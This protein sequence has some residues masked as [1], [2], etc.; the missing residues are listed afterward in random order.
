MVIK[1]LPNETYQTS[2]G[3]IS[4]QP[5]SS[6]QDP[7]TIH[8]Y[9]EIPYSDVIELKAPP[10]GKT[11]ATEQETEVDNEGNTL[12]DKTKQDADNDVSTDQKHD[13]EYI[14]PAQIKSESLKFEQEV[15]DTEDNEGYVIA[16]DGITSKSQKSTEQDDDVIELKAPPNGKT[17]TIA[18]EQE[19]EVDNE[20]YTLMDKT[21][22]DAE[23]DVS[24]DQK[25]DRKEYISPAQNESESLKFEQE[26]SDTED[27]EGYVIADDSVTSKGQ[28]S[29]GQDDDKKCTLLIQNKNDTKDVL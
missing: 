6:Y 9:E 21:K 28:K 3:P 8:I 4:T 7:A 29:T 1:L 18:T 27:N 5:N 20:G 16:D 26:V 17:K 2:I 13:K 24:T 12:M 23:N 10:N 11:I 15:S 22:Q 19:T 25:H 14:P